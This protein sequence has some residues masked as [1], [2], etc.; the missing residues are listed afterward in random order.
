MQL[1]ADE[2]NREEGARLTDLRETENPAK[3]IRSSRGRYRIFVISRK[4]CNGKVRSKIL[5]IILD[6]IFRIL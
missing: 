4:M 3:K 5:K 6:T 1:Y 2:I